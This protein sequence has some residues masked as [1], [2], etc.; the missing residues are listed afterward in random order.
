[1]TAGN[2]IYLLSKPFT[3]DTL[4]KFDREKT[5]V[6]SGKNMNWDVGPAREVAGFAEDDLGFLTGLLRAGTQHVLRHVVQKIRS[7]IE[8]RRIAAARRSLFPRFDRACCAPPLTSG[9]AGLGDHRV[10]EH[11]HP[12]GHSRAD[13]GRREAP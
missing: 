7:H 11:D 2:F 9:L 5:V 4:L 6:S 1:M 12:H 13:K 10:D 3:R 8:F